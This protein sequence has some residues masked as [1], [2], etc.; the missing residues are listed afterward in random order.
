MLITILTASES[1][2]APALSWLSPT[3]LDR[4]GSFYGRNVASQ[5]QLK[6][7]FPRD[8]SLKTLQH[9]T[10]RIWDRRTRARFAHTLNR[11][12]YSITR[13]EAEMFPS[14]PGERDASAGTHYAF[15]RLPT[16]R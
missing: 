1:E 16:V 6:L 5:S 14:R 2:E 13:S 8:R 12:L 9:G 4:Y 3:F 7:H 15:E 11:D 10:V